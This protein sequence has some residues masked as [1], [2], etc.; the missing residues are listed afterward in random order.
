MPAVHRR[1][2]IAITL[3]VVRRPACGPRTTES[4]RCW[5]PEGTP[6]HAALDIH[7]RAMGTSPGQCAREITT[8]ITR[9]GKH[10]LR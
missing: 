2:V 5:V 8:A 1:P 3:A 4:G 7:V 9:K 10:F 6:F